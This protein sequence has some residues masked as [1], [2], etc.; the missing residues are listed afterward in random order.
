MWCIY[1]YTHMYVVYECIKLHKHTHMHV[2]I[3]YVQICKCTHLHDHYLRDITVNLCGSGVPQDSTTLLI[4]KRPAVLWGQLGKDAILEGKV[5][6]WC[7]HKLPPNYI[8]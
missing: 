1:I 4:G 8:W 2:Y 5:Q 6:S 7:C 3:E